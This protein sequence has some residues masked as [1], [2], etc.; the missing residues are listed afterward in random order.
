[1]VHYGI[2]VFFCQAEHL[3]QFTNDGG[4]L[5]SAVSG[6][7]SRVF[8]SVAFENIIGHVV[9]LVPGEV[10]VKIRRR[11]ALRVDKPLEI[12]VEFERFYICD[13]KTVSNNGISPA[14][15]PNMVITSRFGVA[16]DVP[17]NKKIGREVQFCDHFKFLDNALFCPAVVCAITA[18][19]TAFGKFSEQ[20]DVAFFCAHE[21]AAVE[22]QASLESNGT[23]VEHP[24]GVRHYFRLV[25]ERLQQGRFRPEKFICLSDL[26]PSNL[27]TSVLASMARSSL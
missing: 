13:K 21:R 6:E 25:L 8:T 14:A 12:K 2:N 4:V 1:M 17:G 19:A 9:S 27:V 11:A 10:N 18:I 16:H 7:Q 20:I 5:E 15:P 23:G 26:H 22:L 24:A 3:A